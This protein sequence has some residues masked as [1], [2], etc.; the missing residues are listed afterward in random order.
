M[1]FEQCAWIVR[2]MEADDGKA[3]KGEDRGSADVSVSHSISVKDESVLRLTRKCQPCPLVLVTSDPGSR[4]LRASYGRT[5]RSQCSS[6]CWE[7]VPC[8]SPGWW[9]HGSIVGNAGQA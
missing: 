7:D 8:M 1:R 9:L 3:A 5:H 2:K 4:G 6:V